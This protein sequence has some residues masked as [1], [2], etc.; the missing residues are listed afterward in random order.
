[1]GKPTKLT[2]YFLA[3]TVHELALVQKPCLVSLL[4]SWQKQRYKDVLDAREHATKSPRSKNALPSWKAKSPRRKRTPGIPPSLHPPTSLHLL[5][6]RTHRARTTM[7]N[8]NGAAS[9][10]IRDMSGR[11]SHLRMKT[12]SRIAISI[13][14]VAAANCKTP[15]CRPGDS[16]DRTRRRSDPNCRAS[17]HRTAVLP[18]RPPPFSHAAPTDRQSWTGRPT[19]DRPRWLSQGRL[20]CV[21]LHHPQVLSRCGRCSAQ[22]R[23]LGQANPESQRQLERS[24][25]RT[26]A[27]V[28]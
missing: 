24:R 14:L 17:T 10:G 27:T 26:A 13:V 21:L 4:L 25:R 5:V 23:L 18:L 12:F 16:A 8:E 11:C 6:T 3:V 19:F 7:P 28:A 9:P 15:T 2:T 20:S 1:M 22:S